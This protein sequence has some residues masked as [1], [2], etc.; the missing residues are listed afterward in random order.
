MAKSKMFPQ[1]LLIVR[2]KENDGS[3]FLITNNSVDD[4]NFNESGKKVAV[5]KLVGVKTLD[6]KARLR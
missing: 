1:E 2:E 3:T 4:L 6:V 5:Y